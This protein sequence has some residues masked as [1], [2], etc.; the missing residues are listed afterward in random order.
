M[1]RGRRR[2][3]FEEVKTFWGGGGGCQ[4]GGEKGETTKK[5]TDP[6]EAV[7]EFPRGP[8]AL[9][10]SKGAIGMGDGEEGP[11]R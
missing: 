9:Y 1:I 7:V 5:R 3:G 8:R 4:E 11:R 6:K 2:R 10:G